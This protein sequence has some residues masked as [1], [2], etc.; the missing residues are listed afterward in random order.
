MP[1]RELARSLVEAYV[2]LDLVAHDGEAGASR[3]SSLAHED[4]GLVVS[5]GGLE[6]LVPYEAESAARE[7]ELIFGTGLSELIDP[8]QWV[9]IATT[10]ANR[11]LEGALL[12]AAD[13]SDDR[14]YDGVVADWTFAADAVAEALKFFPPGAAELPPDAFWTELGRSVRESQPERVTRHKLES[15]LA[16]YRR[17]LDDFLRLHSEPD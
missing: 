8:G 17:S 12:H 4:D 16:L 6:I 1:E 14:R 5:L 7:L 2:Y 15:D 9:L 11:A 10:Y 13:P 3:R